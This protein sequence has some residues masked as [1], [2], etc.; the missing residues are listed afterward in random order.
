MSKKNSNSNVGALTFT[1]ER[2]VPEEQGNIELEHLHRYLQASEIAVGKD[3][4]DIAS[5]E[6]YGSAM[7]AD[8][9]AHVTGV[10]ISDEAVV[11]A[12]Q[13]YQKNNLQYLQGSCAAIPLPDHS[14][15]L[16]VSFETIEHHEQHEEMMSEFKRVLRPGGLLLISNPDRY[17][18]SDVP[19]YKNPYHVKELYENEFK[20]LLASHFK[21]TRY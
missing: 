1:G 20:G 10:D 8:V 5:G 11:H 3:V 17:Y 7:M 18:Y 13:R 19:N 9:A 21:N 6:G 16:I 2:F 15:D 12:N 4:L 14:V